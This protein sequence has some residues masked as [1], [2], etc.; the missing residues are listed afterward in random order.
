MVKT[1]WIIDG[2][3]GAAVVDFQ[4]SMR[5]QIEK[6]KYLLWKGRSDLANSEVIAEVRLQNTHH[7]CRCAM[8]LRSDL[9]HNNYYR[10]RIYGA[11]GRLYYVDKIVSG[12]TTQIGYVYSS[13]SYSQFTK[14]RFRIDDWQISVEEYVSGAW[15]PK[16]TIEE[17]SHALAQGYAGI[18]GLSQTTGYH[19][20]FDNVEIA[21]RI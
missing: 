21:E 8:I 20:Y 7:Y 12:I 16:I 11:T 6:T 2:P 1:D 15:V 10:L 5:L 18:G 13:T 14:T 19:P 9:S 4:G 17:T 3:G